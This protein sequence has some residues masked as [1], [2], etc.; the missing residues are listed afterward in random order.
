MYTH[1]IGLDDDLQE[2][3]EDGIDIQ[4]N[5]AGMVTNRKSLT[6]AQKKTYKKHHRVKGIF[7]YVLPHSE[8][9]KIID[10]STSKTIF[11]SL[12]ATYERNQQV[13]VEKDNLLVP[14]I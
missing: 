6:H 8:Y 5:G 9:I 3:I 10:K 2:I 14:T 4:V 13:K 1:I 7:V 12:C 11:D